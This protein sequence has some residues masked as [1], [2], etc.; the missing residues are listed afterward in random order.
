MT[1]YFS[2][3]YNFIPFYFPMYMPCFWNNNFLVAWNRAVYG[4]TNYYFFLWI[5]MAVFS[6]ELVCFFFFET[7]WIMLKKCPL[8]DLWALFIMQ[9]EN[10]LLTHFLSIFWIDKL[11]TVLACAI[12]SYFCFFLFVWPF[13]L[14]NFVRILTYFWVLWVYFYFCTAWLDEMV[15]CACFTTPAEGP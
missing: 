11:S 9:L 10:P 8:C 14:F 15:G 2:S 5:C 6:T 3:N 13:Y 1:I 12:P 4:T 7:W